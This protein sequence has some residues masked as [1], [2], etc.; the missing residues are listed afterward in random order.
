MGIVYGPHCHHDECGW[1]VCDH[2]GLVDFPC[3]DQESCPSCGPDSEQW[4][5]VAKGMTEWLVGLYGIP[6]S[7]V[8]Y[9]ELLRS[10]A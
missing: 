5:H 2:T 3:R 1:L 9:A 6:D 10:A 4:T 7:A 8:R